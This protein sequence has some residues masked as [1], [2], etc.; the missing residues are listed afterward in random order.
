[1]YTIFVL[2]KFHENEN[3][4]NGIKC[5][6]LSSDVVNCKEDALQVTVSM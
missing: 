4:I 1:M 6:E 2:R 3:A 5:C